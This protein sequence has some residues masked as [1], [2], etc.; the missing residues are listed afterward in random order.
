M[1]RKSS[2]G[3]GSTSQIERYLSLHTPTR[4]PRKKKT[5]KR[6]KLSQR[7]E[8]MEELLSGKQS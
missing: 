3:L 6:E 5:P 1:D 7:G 4:N 2:P 8:E